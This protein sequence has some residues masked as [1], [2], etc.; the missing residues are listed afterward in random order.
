MTEPER[1]SRHRSS[2]RQHS[3]SPSPSRSRDRSTSPNDPQEF[4]RSKRSRH[5]RSRSRSPPRQR[6]DWPELEEGVDER[7]LDTVARK[8][9]DHGRGFEEVL[10][11]REKGNTKFEFLVNKEVSRDEA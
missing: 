3:R 6:R 2:R 1:G 4:L 8:I 11:E 7:L 10:R 9:R 5:S